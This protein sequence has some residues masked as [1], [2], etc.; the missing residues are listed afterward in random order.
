[1]AIGSAWSGETLMV[2]KMIDVDRFL[3]RYGDRRWLRMLDPAI[4]PAL[5]AASCD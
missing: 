2:V 5:K 4:E 1:M 3:G